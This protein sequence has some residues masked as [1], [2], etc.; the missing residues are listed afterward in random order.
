M[1]E[2][3][4]AT[5]PRSYGEIDA[6]R[7][8][9]RGAYAEAL[10]LADRATLVSTASPWPYY[11]RAVALHALNRTD[12]AAQAYQEAERR[13]SDPAEKSMCLYGRARVF[14]DA[15]RCAEAQAA[16]RAYADFVRAFDSASAGM[17]LAYAA[18]CHERPA[19]GADL[20]AAVS[21]LLAG[22]PAEALEISDRAAALGT[23]TFWI[24]YDRAFALADLGRTDDA[25]QAFRAAQA[26][27]A[28]GGRPWEPSLAIYGRARA[29]DNAHRCAEARQAYAEYAAFVR[30]TSPAD[31]D[32]AARYALDCRLP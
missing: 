14:D 26:G 32:M 16:Y 17:A 21:A 11:E 19:R 24:D 22:R 18:Q 8:I 15:G 7:A 31:A 30:D 10:V 28:P 23:S 4:S 5:L 20:T 1:A 12:A 27:A 3:T 6:R 13:F 9:D 29:L 25:V 2:L